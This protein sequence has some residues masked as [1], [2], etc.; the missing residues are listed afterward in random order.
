MMA[1]HR[2][3]VPQHTTAVFAAHAG[4]LRADSAGVITLPEDAP[5]SDHQALLSAGCVLEAS[6]NSAAQP[7]AS[8]ANKR[9][10]KRRGGKATAKPATAPATAPAAEPEA[11]KPEG[12]TAE[13]PQG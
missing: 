2:Y 11:N 6:S 9:S 13:Q 10:S 12:G 5:H 7:A 3:I 1:K 4:E 8:T